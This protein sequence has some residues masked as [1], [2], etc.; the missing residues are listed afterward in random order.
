[1]GMTTITTGRILAGQLKGKNGEEEITNI[2]AMD[3]VGLA[4]VCF[5]RSN[6]PFISTLF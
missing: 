5:F 6:R 2:D 4:K 3:H 1:M